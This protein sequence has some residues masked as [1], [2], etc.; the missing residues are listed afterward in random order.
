MRNESG[1]ARRGYGVWLVVVW[2]MLL[3]GCGGEAT[4]LAPLVVLPLPTAVQPA[5]TLPSQP[6]PAPE[7][8]NPPT[9]EPISPTPASQWQV[10]ISPAVPARLAEE[11][12]GIIA[13]DSRFAETTWE[14]GK[15]VN[16]IVVPD[17]ELPLAQWVYALVGSF[18]TVR[19]GVTQAELA[20]LGLRGDEATT[21]VFTPLSLSPTTQL[22]AYLWAEPESLGIIPFDELT[23]NLK[24]LAV[25]GA[26][27][28][29]PNLPASYPLIR[30]F[31]LLG[32]ATAATA[33]QTA[34][35]QAGA[36]TSNRQENRLTRVAVTGVTALVRATAAQM[37]S[38]GILW[39]GEEVAPVLQTADIA[40]IS[41]E[42]SFVADCPYPDAYS[43]SLVFCSAD[44]YLQLL[45]H[46][47]TDV[48]ELTGNHVNDYGAAQ[49]ARTIDLY[50]AGGMKFF[51]G[52]RT[53]EEANQP[54]LFEHNGNKIAFVGCNPAGPPGAWA[55][56]TTAGSTP[57]GDYSQLKGQIG[58]LRQEGYNVIATLQYPE[59]YDYAPMAQQKLDFGALAEAGAT[60]VSGSQ[61]HHAAGFGL[62]ENGGFIHYGP[63][64]LFFDQMDMM[65]TRQT[66]VA[67][68]VFYEGR[69]LGVDLWTGLI[70][71]YAR[72]RLMTAEERAL[73]LQ[74]LFAASDW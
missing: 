51:G 6:T 17:G 60:A 73:F 35:G 13:N 53:L 62:P 12:R 71:G 45:T 14:V 59:H 43:S 65:G 21:A 18:D 34:W 2:L 46:L 27:P 74:T 26:N 69:L 7:P 54:A 42:V 38:N 70:E 5:A 47:G 11:V 4:P 33:L 1:G 3:V 64:N 61:A 72:P 22:A 29:Y 39:P 10:A 52:G 20:G 40:H 16:L 31:G 37:E 32:D 28:L 63:G 55:T 56:A 23:P 41:N 44:K 68:Y 36:P 66:V 30:S 49:F 9:A 58:A 25:D 57:C 67:N 15:Q 24:V 8:T 50:E 19:D 48:V